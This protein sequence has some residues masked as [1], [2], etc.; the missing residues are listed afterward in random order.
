MNNSF[1]TFLLLAGMGGLAIALG[2]AFGGTGGMT[3]GL[4]IGV[5]MAMGSYWFSDTLAI[6]SARAVPADPAQFPEYFAIME[7][8]TTRAEL[9]MP[10]LYVTPNHQPNAFATGRNPDHAAVAVMSGKEIQRIANVGPMQVPAQNHL[11]FMLDKTVDSAPCLRHG[12]VYL[13]VVAGR[14][15]MMSDHDPNLVIRRRCER[16][17]HVFQLIPVYPAVGDTAPS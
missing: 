15:M 6:K 11:H 5:A 13:L 10:K 7:E 16:L 9:P 3:I 2:G 8:L 17:L 12:D 1:K 4:M 14:K